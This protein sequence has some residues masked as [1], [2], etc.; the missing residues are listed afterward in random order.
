[1]GGSRCQ[2]LVSLAWCL[3]DDAKCQVCLA[4]STWLSGV[5]GCLSVLLAVLTPLLP[6]TPQVRTSQSVFRDPLLPAT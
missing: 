1:M 4:C 5:L 3:E 6:G 2:V